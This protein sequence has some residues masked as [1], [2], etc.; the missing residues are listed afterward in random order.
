[1]RFFS[2]LFA[3]LIAGATPVFAD[4]HGTEQTSAD[5]TSAKRSKQEILRDLGKRF[6]EAGVSPV[7]MT[8]Q[9]RRV[10]LANTHLVAPVRKL[11]PSPSA[12][13]L[14]I[15]LTPEIAD[16]EYTFGDET[17]R[18]G[19]FLERHELMGFLVVEGDEIRLEH[20][21][22]DHGP[23]A[24]WNTF[25][26]S[27]SVTSM[28]IGAAIKDGYIKSVDE[29]I[30]TYLP[31]M[32]GSEYGGV[33][34]RQA[35]QMSSGM[36]WTENNESPDSDA[37]KGAL[38]SGV[39]L[40]DF[41]ATLP[42]V[43]DAGTTFNYNTAETN[44][45]GEVL[46]AAIRNNASEYLNSKIWQPFGMEHEGNWLLGAPF[47]GETGGCCMNMTLRD[48]ARVGLFAKHE[49]VLPSGERVLPEGWMEESL[50]PS[51]AYPG[52]GYQWWLYEGGAYS[53]SGLFGQSIFIRPDANL[54]IAVH[55]NGP[56]SSSTSIYGRH[57]YTV[58]QALG[59][60]YAK[61]T[62]TPEHHDA[63]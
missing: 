28:L 62:D 36:R 27:K 51:Q 48:Y 56:A 53:A 60:H 5:Q 18:V 9:E 16:V 38:K 55:S 50:T 13:P 7:I 33:T 10:A 26:V 24:R 31:R 1:M 59:R 57:L 54:V 39:A 35:L 44:L 8:D 2:I 25:S 52:Y 42:Q 22:E 30:E 49:G 17:F 63:G 12:Y 41:L 11:S 43:N 4:H 15:E 29:T 32:R 61:T 6:A 45:L 34:I 37:S 46:R 23:E 47:G 14:N 21:A 40:T 19:S 20:Y 58:L 3:L